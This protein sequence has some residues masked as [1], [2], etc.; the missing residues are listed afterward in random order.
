MVIAHLREDL[1]AWVHHFHVN[2]DLQV[3]IMVRDPWV[4]RR[5]R[6]KAANR[7][8]AD[9]DVRYQMDYKAAFEVVNDAGIPMILVPYECL[10]WKGSPGR[11]LSLWGLQQLKPL[12]IQGKITKIRDENGKWYA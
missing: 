1:W 12:M 2:W 4:Q 6:A 8:L 5:S 7:S 11:I 3:I 10:L 9:G